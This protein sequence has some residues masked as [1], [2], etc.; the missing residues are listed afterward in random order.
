MPP[1]DP[2]EAIPTAGARS[3][4]G[5]ASARRRR[6]DG[7]RSRSAILHGATQL[8]TIDGLEGLSIARLAE[9]IGMSK[10]G[11]YAH[12]GSKQELQ[13]ATVDA[14]HAIFEREV[15]RP[16]LEERQGVPQIVALCEAFLSYLERGVFPG[17]CFFA[18][19]AAEFDSHDGPVR[20]RIRDF[21]IEWLDLLVDLIRDARGRGEL[22]DGV[23]PEQL[24]FELDSFLLGANAAFVLFTDL[25]A[26]DRAR[27][28]VRERLAAV[29]AGA[30]PRPA[31]G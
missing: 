30:P 18:A 23:S 2:D 10:S 13:L 12:F 26:L 24:A 4:G 9:H 8:A 14:A 28:A 17:G 22:D 25:R 16:A 7:E 1:I 31:S 6:S 21:Y 29:A 27:E 5:D 19:A 20:D 15:T 3:T 11:L